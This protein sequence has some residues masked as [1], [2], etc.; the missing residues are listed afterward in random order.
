MRA[1]R[2]LEQ[3]IQTAATPWIAR[4]DE[5]PGLEAEDPFA[6]LV[7]TGVSAAPSSVC[8]GGVWGLAAL[9]ME[10]RERTWSGPGWLADV[11][12]LQAQRGSV[13]ALADVLLA[14]RYGGNGHDMA[15]AA[16]LRM[17]EATRKAGRQVGLSRDFADRLMAWRC[18]EGALLILARDTVPRFEPD[19]STLLLR[20]GVVEALSLFGARAWSRPC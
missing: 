11:Q 18:P 19:L 20:S 12:R 6:R 15:W 16:P 9:S 13:G 10:M 5:L 4:L 8:W 2:D 14:R 7:R 3:A 1:A 17:G